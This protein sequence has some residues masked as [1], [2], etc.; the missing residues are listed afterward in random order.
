MAELILKNATVR[1]ELTDIVIDKESGKIL[2][3][4]KSPK[5]GRDLQGAT[6]IAGFVDIHAHGFIGHDVMDGDKLPEMSA[7]LATRGTTAWCP[8]TTTNALPELRAVLRGDKPR[9]GAHVLGFHL[10]G[11]YISHQYCG[12]LNTDYAKTPESADFAGLEREIA[13]MTLAPELAGAM[14]YIKKAPFPVSVGHTAADYEL[15]KAAFD[16]GANCVTHVFNAMPPM[17]HREPAVVGAALISNA[18]VQ[19]ISDGIH[20]HPATVLALY[21]MFGSERMM[22][23]SDA[24]SATGLADGN[25]MLGGKK[26]IVK[27]GVAR[28]EAG[29]LSGSTVTLHDCVCRAISFG[30]PREEV[31][32]MASET[33]ARYLKIKKGRIAPG[34]DADLLVVD[35]ELN[36][37]ET[38]LCD[39][40]S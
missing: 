29:A 17:H 33:P 30:I 11:P 10:E 1:G 19:V 31:L 5:P 14:D 34:Y 22:L 26:V 18:Y 39:Q 37:L 28:N 36:I 32:K 38:I 8:T 13:L 2:S 27:D 12:A 40:L 20:L 16:A 4:E 21:R 7:F 35:A 6:V 3:V 25:Y 9:A 24:I 23:I 15:A